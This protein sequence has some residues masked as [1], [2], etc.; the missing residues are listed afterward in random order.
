MRLFYLVCL[1]F[2]LTGLSCSPEEDQ[3]AADFINRAIEVHGGER[4]A[5]TQLSFDFRTMHYEIFKSP[6]RF[7]YQRQFTDSTG[8]VVDRL[9]NAGFVRMVNGVR[10]DTLSE[11]RIGAFSRSVNSVAYFAFL[12]YGLNDPAARKSYVGKTQVKGEPYHLIKVSFLQEGGG[13]DFDDEFLYWIHYQDY[14]MDYLAYTYHTDG[15]GIR[16]RAVDSFELVG[17]IRFQNYLNYKPKDK[18]TP[19]DQL[20]EFYEK[21]ELILLSEINQENIQVTPIDENP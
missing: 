5:S 7:D 2:C 20:Q 14:T 1:V 21:D 17:G 15:G 13:E 3:K 16:F 19:L 4:Y 6:D 18:N 9:S 8:T 12:P 10:I 11:K